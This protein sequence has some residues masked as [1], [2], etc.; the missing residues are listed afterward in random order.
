MPKYHVRY[1]KDLEQTFTVE[2]PD[3]LIAQELAE[4]LAK[5]SSLDDW[6]WSEDLNLIYIEEE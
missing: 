5:H 2:A 3:E 6:Q 1:I 4:V